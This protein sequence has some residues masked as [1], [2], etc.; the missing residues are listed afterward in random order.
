M[1]ETTLEQSTKTVFNFFHEAL[2]GFL[3]GIQSQLV[4]APMGSIREVIVNPGKQPIQSSVTILLYLRDGEITTLFIRRPEYPGIHSGQMAFP[5]GRYEDDDQDHQHT[6]LRET[7][8]EI[9]ISTDNIEVAGALTPL[10]IPPS[11]YM[12][13]P[14]VA[15]TNPDPSFTPDPAEVSGIVEIPLK[16]LLAPD[17][18]KQLPP[19]PEFRFLDVPAYVF[20]ET[21]VWGA[22][23]MITAEFIA[24]IRQQ[25]LHTVLF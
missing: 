24:L 9:G 13:H 7:E 20:H 3:P 14:F 15:V 21:I 23:A 5:G 25:N 8:E 16:A 1:Q 17:C 4:M 10:Y 19:S 11:N 12:V 6:A 22:T 2:K 18:I